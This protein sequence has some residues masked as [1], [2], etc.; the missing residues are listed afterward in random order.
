MKKNKSIIIT[1]IIILLLIV[2]LIIVIVLKSN[3]EKQQYDEQIQEKVSSYTSIS[4]FKTV[5]EVAK[6]LGC[7]YKKQEKSKDNNFQTDIYMKIK[8]KPYTEQKSNKIFYNKLITYIA[9]VLKYINFRIIDEDSNIKIEVLSNNEQIQEVKI[10]GEVNYF[11]TRDLELQ[12][13]QHN[14]I[15][16]VNFDIQSSILKQ[17]IENNGK[18]TESLLGTRDGEFDSYQLYFD[19]GIEVKRIESKVFNIVFTERYKDNLLNNINTQT[20][21]EKIVEILGTP[22]FEDD[23]TKIIGYKGEKIYIFFNTVNKQVSVYRVENLEG[24]NDLYECLSR[25]KENNDISKLIDDVKS[26]WTDYDK[27]KKTSRYIELVYTLK[28]IKL[29]YNIG[30][31]NGIIVY[32]NYLGNIAENVSLSNVKDNKEQLEKCIYIKNEDLVFLR[33]IERVSNIQSI[34]YMA[35]L[36]K[37]KNKVEEVESKLFIEYK[38]ELQDG[39]Y[40]VKIISLDGKYQNSELKENIGSG[41]W[42]SDRHYIYGIKNKGIFIYDAIN[43]IYGTIISGEIQEYDLKRFKNNTIEYDNKSIKL[44]K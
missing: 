31:E 42:I 43:R 34:K 22:T 16:Y 39:S 37:E 28:G 40:Q 30:S 21:K 38:E 3:L 32:N 15:D 6:Y 29:Q 41:L 20:S 44:N 5:E 2:F 14:K 4:D 36:E 8:L 26:E 1:C 27:Y 12:I 13:N 19:E 9:S 33:E 25:Y 17:L 18:I 23:S 24:S 11:K 10:N 35:R 7:E